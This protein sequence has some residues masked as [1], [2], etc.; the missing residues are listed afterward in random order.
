MNPGTPAMAVAVGA[1]RPGGEE[2]RDGYDEG[3]NS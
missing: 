1:G 3:I 2:L